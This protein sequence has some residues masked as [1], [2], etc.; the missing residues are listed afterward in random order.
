MRLQHSQAYLGATVL[1]AGTFGLWG[2]FL[3]AFLSIPAYGLYGLLA[4][5]ILLAAQLSVLGGPQAFITH[6][7]R[8]IPTVGLL[9]HAAGISLLVAGLAALIMPREIGIALYLLVAIGTLT[10]VAYKGFGARARARLGFDASLLAELS[11]TAVLA[12]SAV[13]FYLAGR[14]C[15]NACVSGALPVAIEALALFV[16]A[17]VIITTKATR[18][19]RSELSLRNTSKFLPF[20]YSVGVL[21]TLDVVLLRRVEVFF[22]QRSPDGA[23]GVAVFTLALQFATLLQ[24]IPLAVLDTWQPQLAILWHDNREEFFTV[25][26]QIQLRYFFWTASLF[27][28]GVPASLGVLQVVRP[29]YRLWTWLI[30]LLAGSR[31]LF[32]LSSLYSSTLYALSLQRRLYLPILVGAAIAVAMNVTFTVAWGLRGALGAHA[33]TQAVVAFPACLALSGSPP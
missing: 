26:R 28:L 4:S 33:S 25:F 15:T 31:A 1:R 21:I 9:L 14:H 10:T 30:G 22:L 3:P 11:V 16:A 18:L 27:L 13:A 29:K 23:E 20:V 17:V 2:L 7:G 5:T 6:A 24:L 19:R 8:E 12:L 32:V